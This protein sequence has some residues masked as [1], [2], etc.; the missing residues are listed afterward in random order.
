M[1]RS[2]LIPENRY[3]AATK[4]FSVGKDSQSGNKS[5][6]NAGDLSIAAFAA[7]LARGF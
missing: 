6:L 5:N 2:N 4:I 1:K 3:R 7:Q